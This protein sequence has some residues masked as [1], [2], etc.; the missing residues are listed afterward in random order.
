MRADNPGDETQTEPQPPFGTRIRAGDA[1]EAVEDVRQVLRGNSA[2]GILDGHFDRGRARLEPQPNLT[3]GGSVLDGV[4]EQ[5]GD[6]ARELG[7]ID[8]RLAACREVCHQTYASLVGENA[9]LL[10]DVARQDGKIQPLPP[11]Y[12]LSRFRVR[13]RQHGLNEVG[14]PLGFLERR[15]DG[16][17]EF[18]LA[19]GG[20]EGD[21]QLAP[22]RGDG[23]AQLVGDVGRELPHL[24][25]RV[26]QTLDHAVESVDETVELVARAAHGDAE[27]QV[28]AGDRLGGPHHV[29][30]RLHRAPGEK[31][32]QQAADEDDH[33]KTSRS[34]AG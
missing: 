2:A 29:V 1:I 22:H 4:G 15:L 13:E 21:L 9:K 24:L 10:Q 19:P 11:E 20:H 31:P 18:L 6:Q 14:Q 27:V 23:G 32:T 28:G 25:E 30:Q 12:G 16:V 8:L 5:V 7:R 26:L 33:R 3:A 17:A 34:S